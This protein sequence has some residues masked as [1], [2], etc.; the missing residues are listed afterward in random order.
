MKVC[1]FEASLGLGRGEF[2]V[3]LANEMARNHPSVTEVI[4]VAP[5]G[6]KYAARLAPNIRLVCYHSPNKRRSPRLLWELWRIFRSERP[7]IVHTHFSKATQLFNTLNKLL[8]LPFVATKHNPRKGK[9]FTKVPYVTAVSK[10][11]ADSINRPDVETIYN[12]ITPKALTPAP[13]TPPTP[14]KLLVVGRLDPIKG[15]DILIKALKS[16]SAPWTLSIV[17]EG[18][19]KSALEEL[20]APFLSNGQIQFLGFRTDIPE[21]MQTHHCVVISSISE[22]FSL[23]MIEALFYSPLLISTPVGGSEEILSPLF[24]TRQEDLAQK[25]SAI[26]ENSALYFHQF[27]ALAENI[28]PSLTLATAA[29]RY[30]ELYK[31]IREQSTTAFCKGI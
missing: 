29:T 20:A 6:V 25:I 9:I 7:D 12:G 30:L 24:I 28:R 17:G 26:A 10:A 19:Q 21:L 11:V 2:F 18:F 8:K 1:H 13:A 31:K 3:D 27:A 23:T 4:I 14:L 15:Y 5:K 16:V 22:G